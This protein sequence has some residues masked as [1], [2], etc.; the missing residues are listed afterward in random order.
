MLRQDLKAFTHDVVA[1]ALDVPQSVAAG[2][3]EKAGMLPFSKRMRN[4]GKYLALGRGNIV[5]ESRSTLVHLTQDKAGGD[6]CHAETWTL[7]A[8]FQ[9][10]PRSPL[11]L[12][13]IAEK[14]GGGE[15][16]YGAALPRQIIPT[17]PLLTR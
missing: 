13:Y 8:G 9:I 4:G 11:P 10:N 16:T 5:S 15:R 2:V 3:W 1:I 17:R 14:C 6:G 12:P 7:I